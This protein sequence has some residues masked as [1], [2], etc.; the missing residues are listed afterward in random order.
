MCVAVI[1]ICKRKNVS[2][3]IFFYIKLFTGSTSCLYATQKSLFVLWFGILFRVF[4]YH[5]CIYSILDIIND[6]NIKSVVNKNVFMRCKEIEKKWKM[7]CKFLIQRS[8]LIDSIRLSYNWL[9]GVTLNE[10]FFNLQWKW[11]NDYQM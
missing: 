2:I 3:E 10:Y 1:F 8:L 11:K 7:R 5:H 4:I 9:Y 6:E